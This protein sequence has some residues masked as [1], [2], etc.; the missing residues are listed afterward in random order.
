MLLLAAVTAVISA[1]VIVVMPMVYL[2]A[3]YKIP[4]LL[5]AFIASGLL[6]GL[7][8]PLQYLIVRYAKGGEM[9]GGA[10][11]QIAFNVSNA[12][13]AALGGMFIR[14]GFGLASPALAGVPCAFIG[15]IALLMLYRLE[16]G[17][18]AE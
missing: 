15:T 7:G 5:F 9:L 17:R 1:S 4:S 14:H 18:R 16:K 8:G 6:F 11:I 10:G 3:A 2:S 12:M 13:A